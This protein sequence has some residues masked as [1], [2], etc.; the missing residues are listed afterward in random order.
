[1]GNT[2]GQRMEVQF[3]VSSGGYGPMGHH[4]HGSKV[5][6]LYNVLSNLHGG[7][8]GPG[9]PLSIGGGLAG[10]GIT[11]KMGLHFRSYVNLLDI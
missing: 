11:Y 7:T 2:L 10:T 6:T 9:H 5:K 4:V 3:T 8:G 1:M